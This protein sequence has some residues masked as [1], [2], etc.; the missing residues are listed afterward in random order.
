MPRRVAAHQEV[1]GALD[2][3]PAGIDTAG[4]GAR[5]LRLRRAGIGPGVGGTVHGQQPAP[6]GDEVAVTLGPPRCQRGDRRHVSVR[7]QV[8][9][10]PG[11]HRVTDH[12]DVAPIDRFE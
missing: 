11:S 7:R 3:Q 4:R 10:D 6:D 1:S 12:H 2:R 8:R 9:G 5:G